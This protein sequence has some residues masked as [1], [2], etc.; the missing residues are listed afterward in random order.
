VRDEVQ[1]LR[2]IFGDRWIV[3]PSHEK[4]MPEVPPANVLALAE[5]VTGGQ[6]TAAAR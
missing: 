4:I 6:R 1:R 2:D 3:S 5:A